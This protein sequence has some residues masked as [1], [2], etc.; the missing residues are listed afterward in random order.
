MR[1]IGLLAVITLLSL[2]CATTSLTYWEGVRTREAFEGDVRSC[3]GDPVS[4]GPS[5]WFPLEALLISAVLDQFTYSAQV[6]PDQERA[7]T[8]CMEA[9]GYQLARS[10]RD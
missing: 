10:A 9:R 3:G 6:V 5:A 4:P 1:T 8:S 2:G 7:F